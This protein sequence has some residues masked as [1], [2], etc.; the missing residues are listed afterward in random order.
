MILRVALDLPTLAVEND[1]ENLYD[2]RWGGSAVVGQRA[3]VPF[4]ARTLIGLVVEIASNTKVSPDRLRDAAALLDDVT[5]FPE[6][7]FALIRFAA[8]YYQRSFG[9]VALPAL[10]SWFRRADRYR[11]SQQNGLGKA[12]SKTIE[13]L[14]LRR[15]R[16]A[17]RRVIGALQS[18][19]EAIPKL[20]SEQA[21]A[22]AVIQAARAPDALFRPILLYGV[23]G[24][25]KTEVYLRAI[26]STLLAGRQA[27]V[28][29]PEINLTPQLE[30]LFRRRLPSA[31][32]A[33]LHSGLAEGE[34]ASQWWLAQEGRAD[35]LL[36][37][38]LAVMTPMP[39]LGLV[40]V[41]EEHDPSYK[42]H[43]GLRYSARDLAVVRARIGH[44][45]RPI[46]IVLASATPALETWFR[47]E[48]GRYEK[49][50]LN[51][52]A[53]TAASAPTIR[54]V[55][56]ARTPTEHGFTETVRGAIA[57]RLARGEP[58]LVFHNRRGYAPVLAC[59]AC[60]WISDCRRCSVHAVFHKT[61]GH[62]HCHHCGWQMRVPSACPTCGN[63]DLAPLGRGT[64][65]VE[66]ALTGWFPAARIARIDR[67]STRKK[68]SAATLLDAVHGGDVDI[69]VG[70][71][72]LA[73][74]HDF[75]NV[76]LVCV[77]DADSALY[78]HDFRAAERL[79]SN[80]TQVAGRA[81][82]GGGERS[83]RAE[84]LIQTRVP[85]HPLFAALIAHDF[86]RFAASQLAERR[87]AGLPPFSY[88][89]V[90]RAEA[91]RLAAA[92]DF[93]NAAR[94]S[95]V[96]VLDG[97]EP[98]AL[99]SV[100]LYDPVPMVVTRIAGVE[101]AQ[102]VVESPSRRALQSFLANWMMALRGVHPRV[103]WH[104]EVDPYEI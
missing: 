31:C 3:I 60:G 15:D 16:S 30:A 9:E 39:R 100:T 11:V 52:R 45:G 13:R 48:S 37:T 29:V 66:E 103:R 90:L 33:S 71:Q 64:Q 91:G 98:C 20:N 58:T 51:A 53:V 87:A 54:L 28:L 1:G 84:V 32:I 5:P 72:M 104:V 69:L 10:P 4:G 65:R 8:N 47:A 19:P 36:G 93:L 35:V 24:S 83:R 22:L 99:A 27:L 89:A 63:T 94:R 68:G 40:V 78:S 97:P 86:E 76:T 88:Q 59:S 21:H 25:G 80:L 55:G 102:L 41:D 75:Q 12:T 95:G 101:R 82:R 38:R 26:E 96:E 7:W 42:Q 67:D 17:S 56:L 85:E 44:D 62:L 57:D 74:G 81:G 70:T 73:K 18:S 77:I 2:Y 92:I 46:P 34:R 49:A 6:A 23:T 50:V 79:F 14:R 61:D 43:E